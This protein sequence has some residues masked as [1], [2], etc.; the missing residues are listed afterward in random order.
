MYIFFRRGRLTFL[1][2]RS[3]QQVDYEHPEI[4]RAGPSLCV[5]PPSML[6]YTQRRV[7][8]GLPTRQQCFCVMGMDCGIVPG[9]S[10]ELFTINHNAKKMCRIS[11]H[12]SQFILLH[13]SSSQFLV[14]RLSPY[15]LM[16]NLDFSYSLYE[17]YNLR[18]KVKAADVA[19]DGSEFIFVYDRSKECIGQFT[20]SGI[21]LRLIW[22]KGQKGIHSVESIGWGGT[23]SA[24]I[25]CHYRSVLDRKFCTS[26][27]LPPW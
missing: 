7:D 19:T 9:R 24:L 27:S 5:I 20:C 10:E 1:D 4:P 13:D 15:Q 22:Q 11:A 2:A 3:L 14:Y 17:E 25:I 18:G 8:P 21:F 23:V 6:L 16:W 12:N 26:L